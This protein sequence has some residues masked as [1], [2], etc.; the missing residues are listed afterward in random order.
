MMMMES[1]SRIAMIPWWFREGIREIR[2]GG[3]GEG[4]WFRMLEPM[5]SIQVL[6]HGDSWGS[7]L[8]IG[9]GSID[10]TEDV[11][12]ETGRSSP[13]LLTATSGAGLL[14]PGMLHFIITI[15]INVAVIVV[16]NTALISCL[17]LQS[18]PSQG[19]RRLQIRGLLGGTR[20]DSSFIT[21]PGR[22]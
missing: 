17:V 14:D 4:D 18:F 12:E 7:L 6:H 1:V 3:D 5:G 22:G 13:T 8:L 9:S 2:R 15:V 10:R 20:S 21:P 11:G 19:D 16:S